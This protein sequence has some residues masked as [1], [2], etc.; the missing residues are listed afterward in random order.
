[1]KKLLAA[2]LMMFATQAFALDRETE[3]YL[4]RYDQL[5]Q[6]V[7]QENDRLLKQIDENRRVIGDMALEQDALKKQVEMLSDSLQTTQNLEVNNLKASQQ[8]IFNDI[9]LLNW[10]TEK[11]D[12]PGIGHHQQ[13]GVAKSPDGAKTLRYLCFD[14]RAL[15]LGTEL[16]SVPEVVE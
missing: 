9:A 2:A 3:Q 10:G 8:K 11:R 14:G 5:I 15:H 6:R 12:C 7:Q 4:Q 16:N 1:M 13:I